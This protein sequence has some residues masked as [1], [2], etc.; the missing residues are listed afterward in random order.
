MLWQQPRQARLC[1]PTEGL[2]RPTIN[3]TPILR[4]QSLDLNVNNPRSRRS[5]VLKSQGNTI[6]NPNLFCFAALLESH[7]D[8]NLNFNPRKQLVL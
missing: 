8:Q 3:P 2:E 5:K 4:V 1:H 7:H 6:Q